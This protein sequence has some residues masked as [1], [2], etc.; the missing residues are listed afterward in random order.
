MDIFYV[1]A[2]SS[3]FYV[4][5]VIFLVPAYYF[6]D[7]FG[8][9]WT[10]IFGGALMTLGAFLRVGAYLNFSWVVAGTA[11]SS[12]SLPFFMNQITKISIDWFSK[13]TV[14]PM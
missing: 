10:L 2:C 13:E 12:I 7:F 1:E 8:V 11:I 4:S 9:R 6:E 3:I 5:Y 14:M